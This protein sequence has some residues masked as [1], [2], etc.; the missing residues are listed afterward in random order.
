MIR[1]A[2]FCAIPAMLM[3]SY[4]RADNVGQITTEFSVQNTRHEF[5][6]GIT[7]SS[8]I[9][10]LVDPGAKKAYA[11]PDA[12][13]SVS[14]SYSDPAAFDNDWRFNSVT[15]S[16]GD[17]AGAVLDSI[18]TTVTCLLSYSY[19]A[20][21][22]S[23]YNYSIE[24]RLPISMPYVR[25]NAM[26]RDGTI[27]QIYNEPLHA[28]TDHFNFLNHSY[29]FN[30]GKGTGDD[31][32]FAEGLSVQLCFFGDRVLY[33][34]GWQ[35]VDANGNVDFTIGSP[36]ESTPIFLV[37]PL[38][39]Y[40][41]RVQPLQQN[42]VFYSEWYEPQE[43]TF[44]GS[45]GSFS[46]TVTIYAEDIL[47]NPLPSYVTLTGG[48]IGGG[49]LGYTDAA[50]MVQFS[51][52]LDPAGQTASFTVR[53][54]PRVYTET[55]IAQV[56]DWPGYYVAGRSAFLHGRVVLPG[57]AYSFQP[58]DVLTDA[59]A[60]LYC[61]DTLKQTKDVNIKR[62]SAYTDAEKRT[63]RDRFVFEIPVDE[64]SLQYR[65]DIV[66][67]DDNGDERVIGQ[68]PFGAVQATVKA[69]DDRP[70][71]FQYVPILPNKAVG[72]TG[73][74]ET[75]VDEILPVKVNYSY[76]PPLTPD[77]W[78]WE[79]DVMRLMGWYRELE[80]HRISQTPAPD[81][82]IGVVAPGAL[83]TYG[84]GAAAGLSMDGYRHVVLLDGS[85]AKPH[86]LL[87]EYL[88]T[89]GLP[90]NYGGTLPP[91]S[92]SGYTPQGR[93]VWNVPDKDPLY[94]AVMYDWAPNA[95]PTFQEYQ[96]IINQ[97]TEPLPFAAGTM[98]AA[99][100][101]SDAEPQPAA[102]SSTG[103]VMLLS[104]VIEETGYGTSI[105]KRSPIFVDEGT[106]YAPQT[107]YYGTGYG[108]A[109]MAGSQT[110]STGYQS[111][112]STING[113]YMDMGGIL[114]AITLALE[115]QE[116][117]D[118]VQFARFDS[119]G[120]LV[121]NLYQGLIEFSDNAP[122]VRWNTIP[123][124]SSVLSG[125]VSFAFDASDVDPDST[126]WAWVKISTDNG[127]S[128][129][130]VGSY[131]KL[132]SA[133]STFTLDCTQWPTTD[134]CLIKI[135]VTDD[136][137]TSVLQAGPYELE[138]YRLAATVQ[139][140]TAEVNLPFV[141]DSPV[142]VPV[143]VR[144]EGRQALE[145]SPDVAVLPEWLR[146]EVYGSTR[147]AAGSTQTLFFIAEPNQPQVYTADI[148]LVTND[149]LSPSVTIP[150][151]LTET[152]QAPAPQAVW[153]AFAG[154]LTDGAQTA[155]VPSVTVFVRDVGGCDK[156]SALVTVTK[157]SDGFAVVAENLAMDPTDRP[158]E[159]ACAIPLAE[160]L[161]GSKLGFEFDLLDPATG[162]ADTDGLRSADY[163]LTI[164]L[165]KANSPPVFTFVDPVQEEYD[166]LSLSFGQAFTLSYAVEDAENDPVS[167]HLHSALPFEWDMQAGTLR[168]VL[169]VLDNVWDWGVRMQTV[170]L[171]AV[172]SRGARTVAQ[173]KLNISGYVPAYNRAYPYYADTVMTG[174]T[175]ELKAYSGSGI[176]TQYCVFEYRPL[177][178]NDWTVIGQQ[179]YDHPHT[180]IAW[181]GRLAVQPWN[182]SGLTAGHAYEVRFTDYWPDGS[183][184]SAPPVVVFR[185]ASTDGQITGINVPAKAAAGQPFTITA[186]VE[187]RS[188][189]R[190][191]AGDVCVQCPQ[192]TDVLTGLDR[193]PPACEFAHIAPGASG[194]FTAK[195]AAP[196]QAG[197]YTT[198]WQLYSRQG[199]PLG[200]P[201]SLQVQVVASLDRGF[202][203]D[204]NCDKRVNLEDLAA[205]C[206]S[207]NIDAQ[208]AGWDA[209]ID[210]A[211]DGLIDLG[212]IAVL[213]QD[214]LSSQ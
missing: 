86:H 100:S 209:D 115:W 98:M 144:N 106:V 1:R 170:D 119:S 76:A 212:D 63:G 31:R 80:K 44:L 183:P 78:P 132:N 52:G 48:P 176:E 186:H 28:V 69:K 27:V 75:Y 201:V 145:V 95:W 165:L 175:F 26:T 97:L 81:L 32:L 138:G 169:P 64:T 135:M 162:S 208:T 118:A 39:F 214:W 148:V 84:N 7:V 87:H 185:K 103:K 177:G 120:S 149:P 16:H 173:W 9:P 21:G 192:G 146:P 178:T 73:G 91:A 2:I 18:C 92:E 110:L 42:T 134:D 199:D 184:D 117:V 156:L 211:A 59:R 55:D 112:Y 85:A 154:G 202:A 193:L 35:T 71:L 123:N 125:N 200:T 213:M 107:T 47:G 60:K 126:L 189:G 5:H 194:L 10:F 14:Y 13:G 3:Y 51:Q 41:V 111:A 168:C 38:E 61:G 187:N 161:A 37:A 197:V 20:G 190:W 116:G 12:V 50:G 8:E 68:P 62:L 54:L 142:V 141:I 33:E 206:A 6:A 29:R 102:V 105:T 88:H 152:T 137:N 94:C 155:Y 122:T 143:T 159:Y 153:A 49:G 136:G 43:V 164:E 129:Q 56:I 25:L 101:R 174:D 79:A 124:A 74:W 82:V 30:L 90:D 203:G 36:C 15:F 24:S 96:T 151:T 34:S 70:L 58:D 23:W 121:Q 204:L 67:K 167:Y 99:A 140:K 128:W 130:P 160:T 77:L 89:L 53:V 19:Y 171:V 65:V 157:L 196:A 207:W 131:F 11:H 114:G 158:G 163:D 46:G 205:L 188:A 104:G 113:Y 182:I 180:T 108:A 195:A 45:Y 40:K 4:V 139:V 198:Q 22:G 66:M 72:S 147:L 127:Q 181:D 166:Y 150:V 57:Q 83:Y 109:V 133:V 179:S 17:S 93:R 172:D 191:D 210:L